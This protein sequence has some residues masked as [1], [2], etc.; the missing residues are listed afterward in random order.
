MS[1]GAKDLPRPAGEIQ[2]NLFDPKRGD[3]LREEGMERAAGKRENLL[4][5][6][7][8]AAILHSMV[9]G[10]CT[11]DDVHADLATSYESYTPADLGNAA[12][13]IFRGE[14]WHDTSQRVKSRRAARHSNKIT[15]WKYV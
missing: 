15:V 2:G 11:M 6:A 12:G 4:R 8:A 1:S 7:R 13:S 3:E 5:E 14:R 9:Y 10:S